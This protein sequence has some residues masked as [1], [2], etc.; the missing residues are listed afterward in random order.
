MG[1]RAEERMDL[2]EDQ[3]EP[4]M[5][6]CMTHMVKVLRHCGNFDQNSPFDPS[7]SEMTRTRSKVMRHQCRLCML[8]M[9]PVSRCAVGFLSHS[10]VTT[11][12]QQMG[13]DHE[14]LDAQKRPSP[15]SPAGARE[16]RFHSS[17]LHFHSSLLSF[18]CSD[19]SMQLEQRIEGRF[20]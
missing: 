18:L 1:I 17:T 8:R 3:M 12:S 2:V 13:D 7:V 20:H 5:S 11:E 15:S 10:R 9:L 6:L 14:I 16:Q 4:D 19:R